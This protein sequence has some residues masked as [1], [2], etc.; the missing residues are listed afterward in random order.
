[1]PT[2]GVDTTEYTIY[3]INWYGRA[4]FKFHVYVKSDEPDPD[5]GYNF[6]V[7]RHSRKILGWGGTT[8]DDPQRPLPSLRR[9]WFFDLSAGPEF[10][11]GN[12]DLNTKDLDGDGILDYRMP[13]V[14]E[15]GN[16]SAA[17]YRPFDNLSADLGMI[18]RYVA[19]NLLFT[20]SPLYKPAI[21]PPKLP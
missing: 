11:T 21:S 4:D 19:I 6:G 7:I 16:V 17:L 9:I 18:V 14:W 8:T 5:T 1:H 13:P 20:S 2:T 12:F 10:W 15:Y 3:F